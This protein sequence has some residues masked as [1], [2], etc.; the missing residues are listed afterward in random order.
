MQCYKFRL[1]I[2]LFKSVESIHCLISWLRDFLG[3]FRCSNSDV[4]S[5]IYYVLFLP[6][7]L[8]SWDHFSYVF[9]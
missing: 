2:N 4:L 3:G 6:I 5:C 8:S 9:V 1:I 7:E